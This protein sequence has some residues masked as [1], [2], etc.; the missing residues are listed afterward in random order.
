MKAGDLVRFRLHPGFDW[1]TGLLI[2]YHKWEKIA[3][4]LFDDRTLRLAARDVQKYGRRYL[5]EKRR[6]G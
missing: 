3:V 4:I 5:S 6:S 1:E 2:E